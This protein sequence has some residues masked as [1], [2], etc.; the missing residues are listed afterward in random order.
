MTRTRRKNR[1]WE[2]K[3]KRR[4][5]HQVGKRLEI[6][7]FKRQPRTMNPLLKKSVLLRTNK[8]YQRAERQLTLGGLLVLA[9]VSYSFMGLIYLGIVKIV[10]SYVLQVYLRLFTLG[11]IKPLNPTQMKEWST[12]RVLSRYTRVHPIIAGI[13]VIMV[14]AIA[15]II[16]EKGR[17]TQ[18]FIEANVDEDKLEK[19][20]EEVKKKGSDTYDR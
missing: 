10:K 2:Q 3:N 16:S 9:S 18:E 4:T 8:D 20:Y 19:A 11:F 13:I 1:T 17:K 5:S 12:W 6:D 14:I 7:S 15:I